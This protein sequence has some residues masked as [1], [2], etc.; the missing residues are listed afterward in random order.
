[1]SMKYTIILTMLS[2]YLGH[3]PISYSHGMGGSTTS[4][5]KKKKTS[6]NEED[7]K[8]KTI[9]DRM[10]FILDAHENIIKLWVRNKLNQPIDISLASASVVVTGEGQPVMFS[11]QSKEEGYITS[12]IPITISSTT[13]LEITLRMPGERPVNITFMPDQST[14]P[15][16]VSQQKS[17]TY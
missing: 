8:S 9:S 5:V 1:M 13:K 11:M 17:R 2:F 4:Y 14:Q 16:H 6:S 12:S 3:L 15:I 7:K 10:N